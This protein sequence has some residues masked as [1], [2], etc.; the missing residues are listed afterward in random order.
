MVCF[1]YQRL[2][3]QEESGRAS[4]TG[5]TAIVPASSGASSIQ[6]AS[7]G[8]NSNLSASSG[9]CFLFSLIIALVFFMKLNSN[10]IFINIK[11]RV[12]R[13]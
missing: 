6:F 1:Q 8:A 9:V 2:V 11:G 12:K 7:S 3:A 13:I 5:A 4:K 10:Q